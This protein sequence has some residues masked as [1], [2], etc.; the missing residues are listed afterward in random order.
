MQSLCQLS[1]PV[2]SLYASD[3]NRL[4]MAFRP[5]HYIKQRMDPIAQVYIRGSTL[6]KKD[7]GTLR[8]S[9]TGM[10]GCILLSEIAFRFHDP[11]P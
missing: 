10:A 3:Q 5:S 6:F 9:F 7:P 1:R 8:L 4:R 2:I 11:V